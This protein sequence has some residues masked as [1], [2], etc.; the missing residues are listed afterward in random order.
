M[1][2]RE[3]RHGFSRQFAVT[4]IITELYCRTEETSMSFVSK[5]SGTLLSSWSLCFFTL[6]W[7]E[8]VLRFSTLVFYVFSWK[9][10]NSCY[11]HN[12][13]N[14]W[15]SHLMEKTSRWFSMSWKYITHLCKSGSC[16]DNFSS[17]FH[18]RKQVSRLRY[19]S[20]TPTHTD[21]DQANKLILIFFLVLASKALYCFNS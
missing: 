11:S 6:D 16:G 14:I 19:M 2:R 18:C 10:N 8:A 4:Q 3:S 7:K 15:M 1:E 13:T 9:N 17:K 5:R 12:D 20:W 21:H